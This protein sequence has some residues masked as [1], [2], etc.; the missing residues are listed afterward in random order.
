MRFTQMSSSSS[1]SSRL[2]GELSREFAPYLYALPHEARD[3]ELRRWP[4]GTVVLRDPFAVDRFMV[5]SDANRRRFRDRDYTWTD[6]SRRRVW[7][8]E[9]TP[10]MRAALQAVLSARERFVGALDENMISAR[11]QP[12]PDV[13]L[14]N[15]IVLVP[16]ELKLREIRTAANLTPD[17]ARSLRKMAGV[18]SDLAWPADWE[19]MLCDLCSVKVYR[20]Q[21]TWVEMHAVAAF[22][23]PMRFQRGAGPKLVLP[24]AEVLKA[25]RAAYRGWLARDGS[26]PRFTFYSLGSHARWADEMRGH[27]AGD[28]WLVFCSVATDGTWEVRT[29]PRYGDRMSLRDFLDRLKPETRQQRISRLKYAIDDILQAQPN[30]VL[31]DLKAQTGDRRTNIRDAFLTM[32]QQSPDAYRLEKRYDGRLQIRKAEPGEP[33]G[34]THASF[35]KGPVRRH[36]LGLMGT[37]A[38]AGGWVIK[39][40]IRG[41]VFDPTGFFI[42]IPTVYV[43]SCLQAVINRRASEDKE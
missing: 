41:H 17:L 10:E 16:W 34:I 11:R 32:Q 43:A 12:V 1:C 27:A 33:I 13:N 9:P 36:V 40:L 26:S 29:P 2:C 23:T 3:P 24:G 25:V 22:V 4:A 15:R 42:L 35:R 7:F 38:G 37:A 20:L 39:D 5:D 28:H 6:D 8:P 30:A 14:P 21:G 19:Q 31:D 18:P